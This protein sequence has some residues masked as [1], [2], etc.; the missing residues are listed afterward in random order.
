MLDA[1]LGPMPL[2]EVRVAESAVL[3]FTFLIGECRY[4]SN[5]GEMVVSSPIILKAKYLNQKVLPTNMAQSISSNIIPLV[6]ETRKVK[7][8]VL[9]FLPIKKPAT[10]SYGF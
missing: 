5:S 6:S 9:L 10:V 2:R 7:K 3:I 1:V 8:P 4:S